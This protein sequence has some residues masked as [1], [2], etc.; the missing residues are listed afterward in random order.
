[1]SSVEETVDGNQVAGPSFKRSNNALTRE[2][3]KTKSLQLN[4]YGDGESRRKAWLQLLD[5]EDVEKRLPSYTQA[6]SPSRATAPEEEV[7]Y[8]LNVSIPLDNEGWQIASHHLP[9]GSYDED[10]KTAGNSQTEKQSDEDEWSVATSKRTR[11]RRRQAEVEESELMTTNGSQTTISQSGTATTTPELISRETSVTGLPRIDHNDKEGKT[12][13]NS[14]TARQALKAERKA[15]KRLKRKGGHESISDI[16]TRDNEVQEYDMSSSIVHVNRDPSLDRNDDVK[17]HKDEGQVALDIRRSF[18]GFGDIPLRA[19][20][21]KELSAVIVGVLRRYPSLNYY[22]G[23]HDVISVLLCVMVPHP[24]SK[25]EIQPADQDAL[26]AVVDVACRLS[27]HFL[28]DAMTENMTPTLGHLKVL[29]DILRQSSSQEGNKDLAKKIE[30]AAPLPY[31][32]LPWLLSVFAHEL[33]ISLAQLVFDYVLVCGP[34]S[35]LYLS[36]ALIDQ[37]QGEIDAP[38]AAEMHHVLS[39][40]PTFINVSNLPSILGKADRLA[41]SA[42]VL[43]SASDSNYAIG[44]GVMGKSSVLYTWSSLSFTE[45]N[46]SI[47]WESADQ[48]ADTILHGDSKEIVVNALPTPPSSEVDDE[49]YGGNAESHIKNDKALVS[50]KWWRKGK[51]RSHTDKR[52]Q[53]LS[54][55]TAILAW[56]GAFGAMSAAAFIILYGGSGSHSSFPL[57]NS[58]GMGSAFPVGLRVAEPFRVLLRNALH[59]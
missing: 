30:Q 11:R 8:G 32:A 58:G 39:Q 29:R 24:E 33:D 55:N 16:G 4:G 26:E 18:I 38:D 43:H 6:P 49:D 35:V 41:E 17:K 12:E 15:R 40:L 51:P 3:L 31:F 42:P 47:D 48:I 28:R 34:A 25:D 52:K 36:A 45:E 50:Y 56:V 5:L 54:N 1:M 59:H 14:E 53:V 23:Y 21:R 27:L 57:S 10:T 7:S 19:I 46:T 13:I 2:D 22:Q 20:R 9:N 44:Q 37:Y